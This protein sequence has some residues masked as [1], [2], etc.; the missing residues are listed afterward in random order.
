MD[1]KTFYSYLMVAWFA[2]AVLSFILLFFFPAPYGRHMK[3]G[4]GPKINRRA[5][6]ILMELPALVSMPVFFFW[7]KASLSPVL[8]V[9]LVMWEAHYINRTM[10]F[11]FRLK[12]GEH[13]M[14]V[15]AVLLAF[16]FNLVNG[17]IN[18]RFLFH[19]GPSYSWGWLYDERFLGGVCLF[20]IGMAVNQHS[21]TVLIGL[22]R[23]TDSGYQIPDKGMFRFVSSPNYLGEILE[24]LGWALATWSLAG[25]CFAVWTAANLVPRAV[26]NHKWYNETF[27]DYPR[28][29]KALIP[30]LL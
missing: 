26:T 9:F 25:L 15:A 17:Y 6:W 12:G 1:E 14:T 8:V 28:N 27:P 24:W 10:V 20:C 21:D 5:G 7:G 2:L 4:W 22:R 13:R 3:K 23:R 11:P 30:F 19:L 29:R 16:F 18:G